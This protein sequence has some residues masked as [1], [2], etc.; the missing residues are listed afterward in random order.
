MTVKEKIVMNLEEI[1]N[2]GILHRILDLVEYFRRSST[3]S[4]GNRD[5]ILRLSGVLSDDEATAIQ[6]NINN[7]FNQIEGETKVNV[8][9]VSG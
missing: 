6:E 7:E 8:A 1:A 5:E 3:T 4:G 2:P 9:I